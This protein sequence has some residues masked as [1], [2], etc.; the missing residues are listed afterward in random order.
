MKTRNLVS[1]LKE[2]LTKND[3]ETKLDILSE[4]DSSE[5][6]KDGV[7]EPIENFEDDED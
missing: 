1:P 6:E 3:E 7:Q 4:N 2:L 5:E